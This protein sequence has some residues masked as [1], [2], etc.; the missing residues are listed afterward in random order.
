M[1]IIIILFILMLGALAFVGLL[2]RKQ[3]RESMRRLE[4]RRLRLQVE[5]LGDLVACLENTIP[6]RAIARAFNQRMIEHLKILLSLEKNNKSYIEAALHKAEAHSAR[7]K[8]PD[9]RWHISYQRD[10]DAQISQ[11]QTHISNAID[12]LPQ[13]AAQGLINETE[14]ASF[15][16]ELRWGHLMVQVMSFI[17]QGNKSI[18]ISDRF[19][20]HS[21]Y[22]KAQ[23]H[24]LESLHQD[25]RRL[26]MIKELSQ[27]IDGSRNSLS[28]ELNPT[29]E[30]LSS[31]AS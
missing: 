28:H 23:Q 4:Q 11:T 25:P 5:E 20:A 22:R 31:L 2:D 29:D 19:T 12:L 16:Q 8:N 24:L 3:R 18:T 17:G 9:E 6:N 7:L 10:S 1:Y 30:Q 21:Y 14:L 13:V 27:M 26:Q 15:T